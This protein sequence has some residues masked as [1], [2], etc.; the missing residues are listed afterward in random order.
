[1]IVQI[2]TASALQ[3]IE[4][5]AAVPG[6]DVCLV[7]PVDLG[8]SI[9]HPPENIGSYAP[10]LG[11]AIAKIHTTTQAA[12]KFTAIYTGSGEAS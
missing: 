8:N 10:E 12:R 5:I 4:Q 2:E 6:I 7:G 3:Q 11:E 1:M 9:G